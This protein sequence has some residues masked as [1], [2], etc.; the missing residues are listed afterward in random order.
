MLAACPPNT[1]SKTFVLPSVKLG[2]T[3]KVQFQLTDLKVNICPLI[4]KLVIAHVC[5][6]PLW[7]V[8]NNINFNI[9]GKLKR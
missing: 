9:T 8:F 4:K 2:S 6:I 5:T 3:C 7:S 1:A